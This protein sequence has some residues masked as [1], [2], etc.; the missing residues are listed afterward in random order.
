MYF[1]QLACQL[2]FL[3][4][5]NFAYDPKCILIISIMSLDI[6]FFLE[7]QNYCPRPSHSLYSSPRACYPYR[8]LLEN[9]AG[10]NGSSHISKNVLK[11]VDVYRRILSMYFHPGICSVW[12]KVAR[13]YLTLIE[14]AQNS[15]Q[16]TMRLWLQKY[17]CF[18]YSTSLPG[19]TIS[20]ASAS[21][22]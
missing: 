9:I 16:S 4:R 22:L 6:V 13:C 17:A 18:Y 1:L 8:V 15:S 5:S 3:F 10:T 11:N 12:R 21:I 20:P 7:N 14:C 2:S 19:C